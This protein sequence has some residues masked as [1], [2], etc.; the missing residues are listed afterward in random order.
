MVVQVGFHADRLT[1][2]I[3]F[4]LCLS[5]S[6]SHDTGTY[7]ACGSIFSQWAMGI[8]IEHPLSEHSRNMFEHNHSHVQQ[9]LFS[10]GLA[11]Y[12]ETIS[13]PPSIL[14]TGREPPWRTLSPVILRYRANI[15]TYGSPQTWCDLSIS[16]CPR[17]PG[18]PFIWN[19]REYS[20]LEKSC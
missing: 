19:L 6:H 12:T 16:W 11:E 1:G 14:A 10:R 18:E 15:P 20:H 5:H 13:H 7:V 17:D 8:G 9:S 3:T 2:E 4:P